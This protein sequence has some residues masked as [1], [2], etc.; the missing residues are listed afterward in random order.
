MKK[1][2]LGGVAMLAL[3]AAI[4]INVNM[5][6]NDD[7]LAGISLTN[8]E[9]LAKGEDKEGYGYVHCDL[10]EIVCTGSNTL[11]CCIDY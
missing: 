8:V 1:K 5:N 10:H 4:G 2:I 11:R 7:Q 9:A 6:M 3:V